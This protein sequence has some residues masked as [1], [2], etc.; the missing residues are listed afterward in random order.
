MPVIA[1]L[2]VSPG[3]GRAGWLGRSRALRRLVG[4]GARVPVAEEVREHT[5][6]RRFVHTGSTRKC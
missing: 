2:A 3:R 4:P 5:P 6:V 1:L